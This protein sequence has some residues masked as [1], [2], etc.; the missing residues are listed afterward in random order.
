VEWSFIGGMKWSGV[1][2]SQTHQSVGE[3]KKYREKGERG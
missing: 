2:P 3:D 1:E